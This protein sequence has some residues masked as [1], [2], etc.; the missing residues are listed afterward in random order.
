[1]KEYKCDYKS[2]KWYK[3]I[4]YMKMLITLA[5]LFTVFFFFF[6]LIGKDID[7]ALGV[8][9]IISFFIFIGLILN[10]LL[11]NRETVYIIDSDSIKYVKL[12]SNFDG[13]FLT[14]YE[15]KDILENV[16]AS[17]IFNN[18]NKYE[19][20]DCGEILNILKVHKNV[21]NITI[22]AKVKEKVWNSKGFFSYK[23]IS[24]IE[25]ESKKKLIITNDY[26]NYD[27][28]CK[29]ISKKIQ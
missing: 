5:I 27:D 26:D 12:H 17:T 16:S 6:Y 15:Y 28:I 11:E 4:N 10:N 25:K 13:R 24:L 2:V 19:G 21:T 14:D 3:K 22:H 18:I 8:T 7:N 9:F 20:I 1:M 23:N 29:I